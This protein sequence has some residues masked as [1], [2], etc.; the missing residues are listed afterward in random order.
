MTISQ[1][2]ST[3]LQCRQDEKTFT[4]R[5]GGSHVMAGYPIYGAVE[6]FYKDALRQA[7]CIAS[8]YRLGQIWICK[9]ER[10]LQ[11]PGH[12]HSTISLR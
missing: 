11:S 1:L 6:W 8:T 7:L 10:L 5:R 4:P 2:T 9:H 12:A 3:L